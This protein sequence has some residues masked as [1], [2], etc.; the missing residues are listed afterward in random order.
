MEVAEPVY[1]FDYIVD[2]L[3]AALRSLAFYTLAATGLLSILIG[4]VYFWITYYSPV[5]EESPSNPATTVSSSNSLNSTPNRR[6]TRSATFSGSSS[7]MADN[8]D[9][10][11]SVGDWAAEAAE[12]SDTTV[13][14]SGSPKKKR[15]VSAVISNVVSDAAVKTA[16]MLKQSPIP[17]TL[18]SVTSAS[19]TGYKRLDSAFNLQERLVSMGQGLVR[20]GVT[21]T[22]IAATA[23]IK[24]GVAYQVAPGY[25]D[26]HGDPDDDATDGGL[27][28]GAT[29]PTADP[30][31][32]GGA[33]GGL[34]RKRSIRSLSGTVEVLRLSSIPG[35]FPPPRMISTATQ[36]E[37]TLTKQLLLGDW[38]R[39]F[40]PNGCPRA[41]RP[42]N[43]IQV[44]WRNGW[45]PAS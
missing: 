4:A 39:A 13:S 6:L 28:S 26:I 43:L 45:Q 36:T 29:D 10:T 40:R 33:N 12:R 21:A 42:T 17:D 23:F 14:V 20:A 35:T 3:L 32:S 11:S 30:T 9:T 15:P 38:W 19:L 34:Q 2:S 1:L 25:R 44:S 18:A 8:D 22:G 31:G 24:A 16:V 7:S 5:E 27:N 37:E 41:V